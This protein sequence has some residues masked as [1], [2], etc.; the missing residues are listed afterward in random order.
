MMFDQDGNHLTLD[1]FFDFI[2]RG[3]E[4]SIWGSME[5]HLLGCPNCVEALDPPVSGSVL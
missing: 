3:L 2:E 1:D 4:G 5:R